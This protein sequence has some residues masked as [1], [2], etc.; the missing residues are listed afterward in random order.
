MHDVSR[1][2]HRSGGT[3]TRRSASF[4]LGVGMIIAL[5]SGGAI[6]QVSDFK[7]HQWHGMWDQNPQTFGT[8]LEFMEPVGHGGHDVLPGPHK[9]VE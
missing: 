4:D 9:Y 7:I 8:Y 1:R 5:G 3:S 2:G 6:F